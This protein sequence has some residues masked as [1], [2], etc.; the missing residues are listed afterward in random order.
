MSF[1]FLFVESFIMFN[2]ELCN[3]DDTLYSI[4][5]HRNNLNQDR[6]IYFCTDNSQN[7]HIIN[8]FC[9]NEKIYS[10]ENIT[11]KIKNANHAYAF[12]NDNCLM[13]S[14][15]FFKSLSLKDT[16]SHLNSSCGG[17]FVFIERD[18][19]DKENA[20]HP[21]IYCN[22]LEWYFKLKND[23]ND[24][25]ND[26]LEGLSCVSFEKIIST[27]TKFKV[28]NNL[29]SYYD[30]YFPKI[31]GFPNAL[32]IC[33]KLTE[34]FHFYISAI[35]IENDWMISSDGFKIKP[36][37]N[38]AQKCEIDIVALSSF[39][40]NDRTMS[41][42]KNDK[43]QNL[44]ENYFKLDTDIYKF[45]CTHLDRVISNDSLLCKKF[46]LKKIVLKQKTVDSENGA[47]GENNDPESY[48]Q[49]RL[50]HKESTD[51]SKQHKLTFSA[52]VIA[53]LISS[54]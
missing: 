40:I 10:N 53:V 9:D 39:V 30:V 1:L 8:I 28:K 2:M 44:C 24:E 47:S 31:K 14:D 54:L 50:I 18:L 48:H 49:P 21:K 23:E 26:K 27:F 34:S 7:D 35:F 42:F 37:T 20:L 17:E 16:I 4:I 32:I 46:E 29:I 5:I 19:S 3:F 25:N 51:S 45:V 11:V 22:D 6:E 52:A 15:L 38:D 36:C 33:K 13:R 43:Y 12:C 41:F